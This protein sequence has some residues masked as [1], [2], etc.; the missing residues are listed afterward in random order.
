MSSPSRAGEPAF[1][2]LRDPAPASHTGFLQNQSDSLVLPT[3]PWR[4]SRPF[5]DLCLSDPVACV[6]LLAHCCCSV[7]LCAISSVSCAFPTAGPLLTK[8]AFPLGRPWLLI[9]P[10]LA[11]M[12]L[13]RE[14]VWDFPSGLSLPSYPLPAPGAAFQDS[15]F[16]TVRFRNATRLCDPSGPVPGGPVRCGFPSTSHSH[17]HRAGAW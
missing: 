3:I 2:T 5:P 13:L 14:A 17:Q 1:L 8:L 10:G 12:H 16:T 6:L 11:E 4:R 15:S 9:F 7:G